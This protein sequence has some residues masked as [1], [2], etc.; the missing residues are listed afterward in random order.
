MT[1]FAIQQR[2]VAWDFGRTHRETLV[3]DWMRKTRTTSRPL[4]R[5]IIEDLLE[6]VLGVRLRDE[7]LPLDR[8]AQTERVNGRVEV[9]INTRIAEMPRVKNAEGIRYAAEWHES[10]HVV[11][12]FAD[13]S[14]ADGMDAVQLP[15]LFADMPKL[16]VCR[17]SAEARDRQ[18]KARE[19]FAENAGTAAA[20]CREDLVR[21]SEYSEFIE[22]VSRGGEAGKNGWRLLYRT[23][24]FIGIN[25]PLLA[26]YWDHVG[27]IK[28]TKG[29]EIIGQPVL[30]GSPYG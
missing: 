1:D 23:A 17:G 15:G 5:N 12:D 20:I 30:G 10:V 27:L 26:K 4:L 7:V 21:C 24:E 16:V 6:D 28:L 14:L 2:L 25:A 13:D 8:F 11:R 18:E 3:A 29:G 19:S 22:L 9:S